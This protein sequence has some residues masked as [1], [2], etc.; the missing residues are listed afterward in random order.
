MCCRKACTRFAT[1]ASGTHLGASTLNE[2]V[3]CSCSTV[4]HHRHPPHQAPR[5]STAPMIGRPIT[6]HPTK[7]ESAHAVSRAASFASPAF[8]P[9]R[10]ADHDLYSLAPTIITVVIPACSAHATVALCLPFASLRL[11]VLESSES[12]SNYPTT[13]PDGD[14]LSDNDDRAR[15]PSERPQSSPQL[16][17]P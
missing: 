9:N 8:T 13:S 14:H 6:H 12:T 7:R 4:P 15:H 5:R 17:I 10:Q 2:P 11:V 3:S 1:T 16:K